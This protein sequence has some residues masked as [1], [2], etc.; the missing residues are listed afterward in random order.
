M[1]EVCEIYGIILV[2]LVSCG[3]TNI[4]KEFI[5]KSVT[6]QVRERRYSSNEGDGS[7]SELFSICLDDSM[8]FLITFEVMILLPS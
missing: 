5:G 3:L 7:L 8:I 6:H 1:S 2:S 4:D